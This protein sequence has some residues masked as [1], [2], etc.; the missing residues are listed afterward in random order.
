MTREQLKAEFGPH[1][2][3]AGGILMLRPDEA[4]ALVRRARETHVRVLGLDAFRIG[5]DF[6]QPYLEHST[7]YSAPSSPHAVD[8]WTEAE[9]FLAGFRGSPFVFEVVLESCEITFFS[10]EAA[11]SWRIGAVAALPVMALVG[12]LGPRWL[13]ANAVE[14]LA[15]ALGLPLVFVVRA[16]VAGLSRIPLRWTAL[17]Y[18]V[19]VALF[20][21]VQWVL[22]ENGVTAGQ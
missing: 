12:L 18:L 5:K 21:G 11:R 19:P 15:L 8:P 14:D 9:R 10:W 2:V 4:I 3:R 20:L 17:G 6:T 1:G 7:D 13:P 16:R 22:R